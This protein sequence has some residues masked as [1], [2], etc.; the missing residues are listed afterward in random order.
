MIIWGVLRLL[1]EGKAEPIE[2]IRSWIADGSL[3][4]QLIG[5]YQI[6]VSLLNADDRSDVLEL[7]EDLS[8]AVNSSRKFGVS[9]NGLALIVAYAT[10][11]LQQQ[12]D[13]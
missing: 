3:F 4:D 10:E 9:H 6:D 5:K 13:I 8:V 7:F 2:D 11:G 1:D 12:F